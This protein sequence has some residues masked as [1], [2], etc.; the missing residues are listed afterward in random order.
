MA[1]GLE[2]SDLPLRGVRVLD[3]SRLLPGPYASRVLL[4]HGASVDKLEDPGGGDYMRQ[5]PPHIDG[6]N[7]LFHALARGT[8]SLVLD[9]KSESGRA[10]FMRLL[11]QYD[12]LIESFR[13][14]VMAKLGL[15]YATLSAAS[16][17][18]IY[19]SISGYGQ[20]GPRAHVAGHDLN[21]LAR[22]GVLGVTGPADGPPHPPG[23]HVADIGGGLF[24][25]TGILAALFAREKTGRGR[26]LDVA[27][28]ES[29]TQFAL[30]DL[31]ASR[32]EGEHENRG[33]GIL[34]GGIAPYNTYFTQDGGVVALAA[35][36]PKFW[37]V[38]AN[39]VGLVPSLDAMRPGPHQR[40]W[41][42]KL[43]TIFA[44]RTRAEWV[45]FAAEHDCCLEPMLEPDELLNDAQLTARR[46]FVEGPVSG[47][48]LRFPVTPATSPNVHAVA[49]RQGEHTQEIL[50]EAGLTN[51]EIATLRR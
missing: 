37:N 44:S 15:S 20:S 9:L 40:E 17:K 43:S 2:L 48:R 13:P 33:E 49:P 24:S 26:Y 28:A 3:L 51:D 21:Y 6:M 19:C 12:V 23:M 39:A 22:G 50:Q 10:A 25:V 5:M 29:A 27:L 41:K 36:E 31:M 32:A 45:E 7:A 18:L 11:P 8:R 30:V 42:E 4:D 1:S 16:P 38:F 14:G 34:T 35:L 46:A 47:S